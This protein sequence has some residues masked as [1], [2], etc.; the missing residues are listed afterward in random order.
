MKVIDKIAGDHDGPV[1]FSFEFFTPKLSGKLEDRARASDAF[2]AKVARMAAHGAAF[3][4]ITWRPRDADSTLALAGRMQ[5]EVGAETMMHL[6]CLGMPLDRIDHAISAV[7]AAGVQNVLALRGDPPQGSPDA[8][9][10]ADEAA[11]SGPACALD[12]VEHIRSKHGDYFGIA[13]A[14]YPEA[15]P[16][17]I[18]DGSEVATVEGYE[19]DLEYLKKKVE[20]GAD[21]IVT[22]LFF[23]VDIFLKFVGDCRRVGI[24]CPIVPGILPIA[25]YRNFQRMT[26]TCKT[27]VPADVRAAV[28]AKKGDE[29]ALAAYGVELATE[30]CRQILEK[31]MRELHFYTMNRE[32]PTLA[33]LRNLG[34]VTGADKGVPKTL[35]EIQNGEKAESEKK[36]ANGTP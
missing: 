18:S 19:S 3:C 36:P 1:V 21:L 10:S 15:H 6:T 34:L 20:A 27:K 35:A 23:D 17:K 13:V 30:M 32:E 11:P 8:A 5:R 7:R 26:E 25:T 4:D 12:L 33:V 9:V 31:G 22:Q 2:V 16:D 28:E 29:A 24:D 14:G